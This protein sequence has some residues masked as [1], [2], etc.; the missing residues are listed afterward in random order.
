MMDP[1]DTVVWRWLAAGDAGDFDAFDDVLHPNAVIHAP[2]GLST[3]SA[4]AE[5]A[6]GETRSP[7][8]PAFAMTCRKSLSTARSRWRELS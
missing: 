3:T 2:V 4:D 7:R 6:G 5:K 1:R 8:S